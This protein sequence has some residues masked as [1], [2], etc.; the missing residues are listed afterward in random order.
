MSTE[1]PIAWSSGDTVELRPITQRATLAFIAAHHR[2]SVPP[3]G[4]V[5]CASVWSGDVLLGVGI[6]GRPVARGLD[7]GRCL[8]ILRVCTLGAENACSMLYGAL[9]KAGRALG[10]VRFVTYTRSDE[11]GTSLRAAGFREVARV[12]GR[13]WDTPSRRRDDRDERVDRVRWEWP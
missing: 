11:N 2:H 4:G 12:N 7:D 9:R 8:E 10:Y 3:R 5:F 6:A 13:S 1:L